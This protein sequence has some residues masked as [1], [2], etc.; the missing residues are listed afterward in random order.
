MVG[1]WYGECISPIFFHFK[2]VAS[3]HEPKIMSPWCGKL[4]CVNF[5]GHGSGE[6]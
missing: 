6:E 5:V 3:P 2:D 1:L 4:Y